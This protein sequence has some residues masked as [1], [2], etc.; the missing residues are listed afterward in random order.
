MGTPEVSIYR[1]VSLLSHTD[2]LKRFDF[3]A[4]SLKCFWMKVTWTDNR[5]LLEHLQPPTQ[6]LCTTTTMAGRVALPSLLAI[7]KWSPSLYRILSVTAFGLTSLHIVSGNG[8]PNKT[9]VKSID[10]KMTFHSGVCVAEY[11]ESCQPLLAGVTTESLVFR[12]AHA[13]VKDPLLVDKF[14]VFSL[15]VLPPDTISIQACESRLPTVSDTHIQ[16]HSC[17]GPQVSDMLLMASNCSVDS[18]HRSDCCSRIMPQSIR[19][20]QQ[21]C[22]EVVKHYQP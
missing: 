16:Q 21:E 10:K 13:A 11:Q 4:E 8:T 3:A 22:F 14:G 12:G 9:Y 18:I 17:R 7:P 19:Q 1:K 2:L 15:G 20:P 6:K 5:L